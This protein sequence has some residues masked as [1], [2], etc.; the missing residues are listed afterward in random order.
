MLTPWKKSCDKSRQC[1][2]KHDFADKSLYSQSY[3]FFPVIMYRCVSWTIKKAEHWRIDGFELWCWRT[4]ES[5]LD[6]KQIKLVNPKGNQLWISIGRT[7][8]KAEALIL[9]PPDVKSWLIGKDPDAGK[10]W[11]QE[12]K[13]VT[14]DNM[15]GGY[16]QLNGLEFEQTLGD[17]EGQGSLVCCPSWTAR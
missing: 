5:L 1:I 4:L 11:G 14:K 8:A 7:D 15:V 10:D 6:C 17:N 16:H 13:E 3:G 9:W 12:E 2:K